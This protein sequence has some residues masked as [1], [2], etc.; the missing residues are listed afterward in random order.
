MRIT[1]GKINTQVLMSWC[2][3]SACGNA[4]QMGSVESAERLGDRPC[5]NRHLANQQTSLSELLCIS[6]A[7]QRINTDNRSIFPAPTSA[8][9]PEEGRDSFLASVKQILLLAQARGPQNPGVRRELNINC[10]DRS[11]I[12]LAL[13]NWHPATAIR[14]MVILKEIL[15]PLIRSAHNESWHGVAHCRLWPKGSSL[16]V[17]A[18]PKPKWQRMLPAILVPFVTNENF[19]GKFLSQKNY[20]SMCPPAVRETTPSGTQFTSSWGLRSSQSSL[21]NDVAPL[22]VETK[23]Y[24]QYCSLEQGLKQTCL[25]RSTLT[26]QRKSSPWT[27]LI[28]RCFLRLIERLRSWP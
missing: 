15:G 5:F 21:S 24:W 25:V 23:L 16:L 20:W 22:L 9:N 2:V 7:T 8:P 1:K 6:P 11:D 3:K 14:K 13:E 10:T 4:S 18:L 19:S 28:V 27:A 26:N 12:S 17:A